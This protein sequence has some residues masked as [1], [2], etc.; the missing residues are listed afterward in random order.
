M[1]SSKRAVPSSLPTDVY[2]VLAGFAGIII[3]VITVIRP[4]S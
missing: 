1:V 3:S 2:Y 4:S